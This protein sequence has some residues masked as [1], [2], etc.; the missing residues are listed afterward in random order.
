LGNIDIL[1]N[2]TYFVDYN[3]DILLVSNGIHWSNLKAPGGRDARVS[4]IIEGGN[5]NSVAPGYLGQDIES[6]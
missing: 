6:N 3:I 5:M 2:T 4:R 1:S